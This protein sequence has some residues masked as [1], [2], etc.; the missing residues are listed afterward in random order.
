MKGEQLFLYMTHRLSL[1]HIAVNF[2]LDLSF[3]CLLMA[4]TRPVLKIN[5]RN[6]TPKVSQGKQLFLYVTYHVNLI[7]IAAWFHQGYLVM[8]CTNIV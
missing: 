5:H 1:I 4:C 7:Y 6:V 8:A 3:G 2:H